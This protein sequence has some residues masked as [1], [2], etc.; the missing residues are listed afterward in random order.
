MEKIFH[1][2][3]PNNFQTFILGKADFL[4]RN[5][6]KYLFQIMITVAKK[7]ITRHW[8]HPDPPTLEEWA[9]T[10]NDIYVMEK[11][12]FSLNL[13]MDKFTKIWENWTLFMKKTQTNYI[14]PMD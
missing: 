13:Q 1:T 2:K 14:D 7:N 3:I 10:I 6:D 9:D 11:I 4:M 12:T 5:I 8:L